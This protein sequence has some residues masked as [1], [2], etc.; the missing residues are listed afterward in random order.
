MDFSTPPYVLAQ[1]SVRRVM[2]QVLAA[3]L[4]G[5]AAYVWLVGASIVLQLADCQPCGAGRRG[6]DA[7]GFVASRSRCS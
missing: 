7:Y 3:L 1:T 6:A 2:L 4:P 5:I